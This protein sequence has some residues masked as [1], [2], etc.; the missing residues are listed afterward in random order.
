MDLLVQEWQN[1]TIFR[2]VSLFEPLVKTSCSLPQGN[3]GMGRQDETCHV[4][5]YPHDRRRP[6]YGQL[7]PNCNTLHPWPKQHRPAIRSGKP[8][9]G[10]ECQTPSNGP[11]S[12]CRRV[13]SQA[14]VT[15]LLFKRKRDSKCPGFPRPGSFNTRACKPATSS[16]R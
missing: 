14:N 16:H 2:Q 6:W 3:L 7:W 11:D 4:C 8:G 15:K 5:N 12:A 10:Q 13:K 9:H 1:R